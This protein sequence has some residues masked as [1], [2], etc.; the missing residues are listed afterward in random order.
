M[1]KVLVSES[2]L[3]NIANAIR[4]KDG[5]S[6]TI[7]PNEMATAITNIPTG[8]G[9]VEVEEK[10]VNFF[11]YDGTVI[12]SYTTS[13]FLAL[14]SLPENPT[15][16]GLIAQ[17]WNWSLSDA[18]AYV[19]NHGIL[20]IGQMYVTDDNKT[21]IYINLLPD[22]LSPILC[23]C[24]N[25]TA[26]V[27]WGDGST[28]TI[29]G[30]SPTAIVGTEH[31]YSNPGNYVITLSSSNDIY[32]P[33]ANTT[34]RSYL[35]SLNK[36]DSGNSVYGSAVKK[37]ELGSN[38]RL[39]AYALYGLINLKS[40]TIPSN[41]AINYQNIITNTGIKYITIPTGTASIST[42]YLF[43][44]TKSL[45]RISIPNITS[46][47][48]TNLF[49]GSSIERV[50]L[51]DGINFA[52]ANSYLGTSSDIRRLELPNTM[53]AMPGNIASSSTAL[54]K[55]KIPSSVTT[56]KSQSFYFM[57]GSRMFDFR[58]HTSIPTLANADAFNGTKAKIVVPDDLYADWI[59]AQNWSNFVGFDEYRSY[60]VKASDYEE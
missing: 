7:T 39:N 31:K 29:T 2:N 36:N 58:N 56:I 22:L 37:I 5:T 8:G 33:V 28:E 6:S 60:I 52:S 23:I 13:E 21:R 48:G 59:V 30:T 9:T 42:N 35:L 49:N 27:D 19:T 55:I 46:N 32:I 45:K 40:I 16:S 51:P 26:T 1:A 53:T 57:F 25:G 12:N 17:G 10:D 3:Q 44:T 4:A 24:I 14:E 43:A 15:H 47:C 18:K 34:S 50:I 41:L 38:I 11:D 54:G 20:D